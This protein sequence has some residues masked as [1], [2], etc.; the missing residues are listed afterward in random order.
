MYLLSIYVSVFYVAFQVFYLGS[1]SCLFI[2]DLW[3]CFLYIL[4][5]SPLLEIDTS[6]I[7]SQSLAYLIIF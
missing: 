2:N 5:T 6:D 4:D 1:V 3:E 7:F